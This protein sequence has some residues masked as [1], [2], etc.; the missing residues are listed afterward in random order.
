M[1]QE[2]LTKL[3]VALREMEDRAAEIREVFVCVR[4]GALVGCGSLSHFVVT[5]GVWATAQKG[6]SQREDSKERYATSRI[7]RGEERGAT[8]EP[9]PENLN[10]RP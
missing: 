1:Q 2:H 5:K 4:V 3:Q 6:A 10:P 8:R 7:C 9:K